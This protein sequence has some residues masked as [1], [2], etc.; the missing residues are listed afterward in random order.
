MLFGGVA[1][2]VISNSFSVHKHFISYTVLIH[3]ANH[4]YAI[5][6]ELTII[7]NVPVQLLKHDSSYDE[8]MNNS[9]TPCLNNNQFRT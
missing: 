7:D 3:V 4:D 2:S 5:V 8:F 9:Q 1:L 6:N